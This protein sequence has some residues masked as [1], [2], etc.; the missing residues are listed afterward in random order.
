[1]HNKFINND[2]N[3]YFE[4][5]MNWDYLAGYF[6]ADGSITWRKE[7]RYGKKVITGAKLAITSCDR[8]VIEKI[9]EFLNLPCYHL[10]RKKHGWQDT[11]TVAT[12]NRKKLEWIIPELLK[13]TF[14]ERKKKKLKEVLEWYKKHEPYRD[15]KRKRLIEKIKKL[16]WDDGMTMTE[17]AE[18]LGF[19]Q[20]SCISYY[21]TRYKIPKRNNSEAMKKSWENRRKNGSI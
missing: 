13:R 10:E 11:Y 12:S 6:E 16:Y 9:A 2:D 21:F 4:Y 19:K 20:A 18:K 5:K 8:D 7:I 3:R 1:L 15:S 14:M 17:I